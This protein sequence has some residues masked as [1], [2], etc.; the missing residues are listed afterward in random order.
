MP[1]MKMGP[2]R[3]ELKNTG[4]GAYEGRGVIVRCPSGRRTWFAHVTIP[5]TGEVKFIFDVIY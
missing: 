3:V 4:N 2:N 1:G 5:G